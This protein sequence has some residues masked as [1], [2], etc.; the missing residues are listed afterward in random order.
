MSRYHLNSWAVREI[1][2]RPQ[3]IP[4]KYSKGTFT[5]RAVD[6]N[7]CE[8]KGWA[9]ESLWSTVEFTDVYLEF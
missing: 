8:L 3:E 7:F 6:V 5:E 4:R 2:Q 1:I 9:G